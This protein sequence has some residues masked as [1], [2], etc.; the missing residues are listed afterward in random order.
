MWRGSFDIGYLHICEHNMY[1]YIY[2]LGT[3]MYSIYYFHDTI[4]PT[5]DV[6]IIIRYAH[7]MLIIPMVRG[8]IIRLHLFCVRTISV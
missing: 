3:C 1:I 6:C 4:P 5:T 8:T 2:I 7:T